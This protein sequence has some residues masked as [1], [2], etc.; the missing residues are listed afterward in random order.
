MSAVSMTR[1]LIFRVTS[2]GTK[3]AVAAQLSEPESGPLFRVTD[4]LNAPPRDPDI[5]EPLR[6]AAE[7][8]SEHGQTGVWSVEL[9]SP[10]DRPP[11]GF[12]LTVI[13][14]DTDGSERVGPEGAT[15]TPAR[16]ARYP[17]QRTVRIMVEELLGG[18]NVPLFTVSYAAETPYGGL[19][20]AFGTAW[21]EDTDVFETLFDRIAD[22]VTLR[23]SDQ[24]AD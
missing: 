5:C 9:P 23:T 24:S 4:L 13:L 10:P 12:T 1:D 21:I 19:I 16:L 6:D 7:Q 17:A 22:S 15:V 20:V 14:A 11:V 2:R 3:V 18:V 8:T